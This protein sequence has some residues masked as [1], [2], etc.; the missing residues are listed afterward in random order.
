M[1]ELDCIAKEHDGDAYDLDLLVLN[2]E[3]EGIIKDLVHALNVLVVR[4]LGRLIILQC[5]KL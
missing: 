2:A 1:D 3:Q 4:D 5:L